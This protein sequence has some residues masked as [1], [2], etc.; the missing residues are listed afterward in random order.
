MGGT[1]F[2]LTDAELAAA[3]AY[4]RTAAY[5]RIAV[6]LASGKHA[7]VYVHAGSGLERTAR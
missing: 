4:E 3:D 5:E 1:L 7:W 6:V 2:A